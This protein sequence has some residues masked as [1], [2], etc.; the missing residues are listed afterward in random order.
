MGPSTVILSGHNGFPP[1]LDNCNHCL[2]VWSNPFYRYVLANSDMPLIN[3]NSASLF[4][5]SITIEAALAVKLTVFY[6]VNFQPCAKIRCHAEMHHYC[7]AYPPTHNGHCFMNKTRASLPAYIPHN[8]PNAAFWP[9][10]AP[11]NCGLAFID[12]MILLRAQGGV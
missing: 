11:R 12:N 10:Y 1:S 6:P 8:S 9:I 3:M 7:F 5:S 4:T 2:E